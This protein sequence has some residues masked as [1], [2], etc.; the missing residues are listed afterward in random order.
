MAGGGQEPGLESFFSLRRSQGHCQSGHISVLS[1]PWYKLRQGH[2][3]YRAALWGIVMLAD[4][5][6]AEA[7]DAVSF[8]IQLEALGQHPMP[9]LPLCTWLANLEP[10]AVPLALLLLRGHL[11]VPRPPP[12]LGSLQSRKHFLF[13]APLQQF[14][15]K[16]SQCMNKSEKCYKKHV[17]LLPRFLFPLTFLLLKKKR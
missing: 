10:T 7:V 2:F 5:G 1:F 3:L 14:L 13:L 16:I 15:M 17:D 8:Q 11:R 9:C 4:V 12:C 6:K